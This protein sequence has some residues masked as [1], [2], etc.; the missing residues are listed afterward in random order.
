[1]TNKQAA[2]F[3]IRQRRKG[4]REKEILLDIERRKVRAFL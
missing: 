3:L 2:G 4:K 1:M